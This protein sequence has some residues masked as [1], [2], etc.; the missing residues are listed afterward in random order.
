MSLYHYYDGIEPVLL[1]KKGAKF[2]FITSKIDLLKAVKQDELISQKYTINSSESKHGLRLRINKIIKYRGKTREVSASTILVKQGKSNVYTIITFDDLQ[3]IKD[4]IIRFLDTYSSE[5]YRLTLTSAKLEDL[6]TK[7]KESLNCNII[8]DKLVSYSRINN[9]MIKIGSSRKREADLRWT[10]EDYKES[11]S[12]A[13][14]NN[15]W[16]DKISFYARKNKKTLFRASLSRSGLF[17]IDSSGVEFYNIITG[18][19]T[20]FGETNIKLFSDKSRMENEGA[21]KP[22]TIEYPMKIFENV[23]QNKKLISA[24]S[25]FPKS[26]S[27]VY[28]GNPYLHMSIVDYT[29]GSSYDLWVISENRIIIVPQLKATFKSLSRISEHIMKSFFEGTVEEL[30][31]T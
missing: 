28:H 17:E 24:I 7:I 30:V 15:Q 6:L 14:K 22:I 25:E 8:T 10:G 21:I 27:F 26:N 4:V 18:Y 19:L 2:I 5:L 3:V 11:F 12:R 20:G 9:E 23:E 29:D 31:I 1:E 13:L 16:I